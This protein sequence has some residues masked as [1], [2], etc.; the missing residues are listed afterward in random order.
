MTQMVRSM[1][2]CTE[3]SLVGCSGLPTASSAFCACV[4]IDPS[5]EGNKGQFSQAFT[6]KIMKKK[7]CVFLN[8]TSILT[9]LSQGKVMLS[10]SFYG[11]C[12]FSFGKH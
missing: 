3:R 4:V 6:H 5:S 12:P 10:S 11:F 2:G 9:I 7:S 1:A 8:Q